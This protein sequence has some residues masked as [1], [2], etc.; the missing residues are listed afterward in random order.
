[1][2][3]M[4]ANH[5]GDFQLEAGLLGTQQQEEE[6]TPFII[7][8]SNQ[9]KPTP[10]ICPSEAPRRSREMSPFRR[11][12]LILGLSLFLG[13][14]LALARNPSMTTSCMRWGHGPHQG[15]SNIARTALNKRQDGSLTNAT[16]PR[17]SN[18]QSKTPANPEQSTPPAG[19]TSA[20]LPLPS[21]AAPPSSPAPQ[22]TPPS[23]STPALPPTPNNPSTPAQAP[24]ATSPIA[25]TPAQIE[26]S[27]TPS[28][29]ESSA[30]TTPDTVPTSTPMQKTI[31]TGR[32][33]TS[34]P[35]PQVYTTVLPN[36]GTL[37]ITSTSWVAI[38]PTEKPTSSSEPKLQNAAPK[39]RGGSKLF[40]AVGAAAVGML[41]F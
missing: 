35:V 2:S 4:A 26:T 25:T 24:P 31:T 40:L 22:V 14:G 12:T 18:D 1:M 20:S 6:K 27:T 23:A 11:V 37:T 34:S 10:V 30:T 33:I 5:N 3:P 9:V 15:P 41:L 39:S 7:P 38:V 16:T 28:N 17:P 36:G 32:V 21:K 19:V 8:G 13:L 29:P